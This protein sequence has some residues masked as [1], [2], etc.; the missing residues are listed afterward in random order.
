VI[1]AALTIPIAN[2]AGGG[3]YRRVLAEVAAHAASLPSTNDG[4]PKPERAPRR[5]TTE[6]SLAWM[7]DLITSS[8]D[9]LDLLTDRMQRAVLEDPVALTR[10]S[11]F[12][13]PL[14]MLQIASML[15]EWQRDHRILLNDVGKAPWRRS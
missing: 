15:A 6:A 14:R 7:A 1:S 2:K 4:L 8:D 11:A 12:S 9:A 10:I 13:G 3:Y 5:Q